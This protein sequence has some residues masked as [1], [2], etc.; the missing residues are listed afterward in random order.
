MASALTE[1][2]VD[3]NLRIRVE[4]AFVEVLELSDTLPAIFGGA[5]N[6]NIRRAMDKKK[7]VLTGGKDRRTLPAIS[8]EA[9]IEQTIPRTNEYMARVEIV[10][11]TSADDD[12]DAQ[13]VEALVGAVRDQLHED[14]NN[15][16]FTGDNEGFLESL[17]ESNRGLV[18]HQLHEVSE[19]PDDEGK[20][21]R[22]KFMCDT[23]FF[24]GA[25]E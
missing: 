24:P 4:Q 3:G 20:T 12:D 22:R 11:A 14:K 5:G 19:D 16:G 8:V 25:T 23:W 15:G 18:F 13:I 7:G 9:M 2:P 21:R 10:C 17:N 6:V 1:F